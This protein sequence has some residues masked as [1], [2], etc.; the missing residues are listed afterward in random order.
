MLASGEQERER[1]SS[2]AAARREAIAQAAELA[3]EL[4]EKK[5]QVGTELHR[6]LPASM[7]LPEQCTEQC[8]ACQHGVVTCSESKV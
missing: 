2:S 1:S 5:R 8:C 6:W 7:R 3:A 4:T